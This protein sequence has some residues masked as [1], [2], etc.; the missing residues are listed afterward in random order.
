MLADVQINPNPVGVRP[1]NDTNVQRWICN[2]VWLADCLPVE[3]SGCEVFYS[4][5][6]TQRPEK[7]A[8]ELQTSVPEEKDGNP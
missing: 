7:S 1:H 3:C 5:E 4:K 2:S 8:H 6:R